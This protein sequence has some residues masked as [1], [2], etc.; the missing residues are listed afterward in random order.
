LETTFSTPTGTVAITDALAMGD[1]NRGHELGKG[2][3]VP[4]TRR[5]ERRLD[6]GR[7]RVLD[8]SRRQF[9][10]RTGPRSVSGSLTA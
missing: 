10:P 7:C 5:T 3:I 4:P 9:E 8:P 2:A 6:G 1:G